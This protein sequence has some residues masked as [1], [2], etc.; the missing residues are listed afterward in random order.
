MIEA[1]KFSETLWEW[2]TFCKTFHKSLLST[3]RVLPVKFDRPTKMTDNYVWTPNCNLNIKLREQ[4]LKIKQLLGSQL[5]R[6]EDTLGVSTYAELWT[7]EVFSFPISIFLMKRIAEGL[8]ID[9]ISKISR[10]A[11]DKEKFIELLQSQS[12]SVKVLSIS[13]NRQQHLLPIDESLQFQE[14]KDLEKLATTIEV[15]HVLSPEDVYTLSVE[16][17]RF[18]MVRAA[19]PMLMRNVD[20][21]VYRGMVFM[22]YLQVVKMW[23]LGKKIFD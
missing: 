9:N 4:D 2:R 21:Q 18:D 16:H 23:G 15:S 3:I 20:K 22:N 5:C 12:N 6:T 14:H 17:P 19:I 13:K 11:D 7:T 8:K 1:P 10:G